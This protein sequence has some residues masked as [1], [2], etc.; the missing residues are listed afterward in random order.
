[1]ALLLLVPP[2]LITI[3]KYV[4]DGDERL[5]NSIAPVLLGIFPLIM[6]F[7]VTSI[8]TLR[9]RSR[10]TLDR[11]M[12]LPVAKVDI[13]LGYMI[14]F[15]V[16]ALV[17][18]SLTCLVMF[19]FLDVSIAGDIGTVLLVAVLSALLGT[20]A[21]LFASA[22]AQSEFQ[23]VQFMPAFI[24]P[25]L[26]TCGLFTVRDKMAD[27][28][29]WMSDFLPLTYCVDATKEAVLHSD[30]SSTLTN[31]ILVMVAFIVGFVALS[32]VSIKRLD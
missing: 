14:A 18:V 4:F 32:V 24:F 20:S 10:G 28:L 27:F 31:D 23:A 1:M 7:L 11:L 6:M 22:F 2:I 13:L 3:L 21:G 8:A 12:T 9:E 30:W 17:Q 19:S 25:Q 15:S 29:Q 5:F 16:V 26:L